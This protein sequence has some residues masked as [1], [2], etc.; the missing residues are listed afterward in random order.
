[1]S[2]DLHE[3]YEAVELFAGTAWFSRA[4]KACGHPTASMDIIMEEYVSDYRG[5]H[6]MDLTTASGFGFLDSNFRFLS[7]IA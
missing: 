6:A 3:V 4:M 7:P 1:M 2:C 5:G